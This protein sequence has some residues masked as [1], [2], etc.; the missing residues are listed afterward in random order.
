MKTSKVV[1]LVPEGR[2]IAEVDVPL[3]ET[4]SQ[5]SPCFSLDDAEKLDE[6]RFALRRGEGC[7]CSTSAFETL[8]S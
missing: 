4:D 5:W 7:R 1:E 3:I 6:V 2:Y 8:T